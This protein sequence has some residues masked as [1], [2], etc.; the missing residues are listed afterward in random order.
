MEFYRNLLPVNIRL[1][2]CSLMVLN[3]VEAAFGYDDSVGHILVTFRDRSTL[4]INMWSL[5]WDGDG[6]WSPLRPLPLSAK[7]S[8]G[9]VT[10]SGCSSGG[11]FRLTKNGRRGKI[12]PFVIPA[13][14]HVLCA[15]GIPYC[16]FP[17][18][19]HSISVSKMA[20][21]SGT[22]QC[23]CVLDYVEIGDASWENFT[24]RDTRIAPVESLI[25]I[26][27]RNIFNN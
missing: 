10:A 24:R 4:N 26:A 8:A 3:V 20:Y 17:A 27:Y 13:E 6:N 9:S 7:D 1:I 14:V 19:A 11:F 16:S 23:N 22:I 18:V 15:P 12:A 5:K 21:I 25:E 2:T